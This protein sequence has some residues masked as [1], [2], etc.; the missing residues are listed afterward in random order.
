MIKNELLI[1]SF[2]QGIFFF[3]FLKIILDYLNKDDL[4]QNAIA[5]STLIFIPIWIRYAQPSFSLIDFPTGVMFFLS[6]LKATEIIIL[7]DFKKDNFNIIIILSAL[8]FLFKF[9]K[10]IFVFYF[11]FFL[12]IVLI[13]KKIN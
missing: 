12:S 2:F 11:I 8:L 4:T 5:I 9:S 10:L 3:Y 7:K 13:N 1:L 6:F